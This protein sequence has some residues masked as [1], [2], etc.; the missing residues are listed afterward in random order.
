MGAS[1]K[2]ATEPRLYQQIVAL[3][4]QTL[5]KLGCIYSQLCLIYFNPYHLI[6]YNPIEVCIV[7]REI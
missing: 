4:E 5:R 2:L 7:K 3:Q 6:S 1:V